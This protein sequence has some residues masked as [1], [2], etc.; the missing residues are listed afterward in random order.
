[1][2]GGSHLYYDSGT[3]VL[4]FVVL[5]QYLD[6]RARERATATLAPGIETARPRAHVVEETGDREVA[7]DKVG[8]GERVRVQRGRKFRSTAE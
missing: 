5:G 1:M 8:R 3:M 2:R 7:P 6:A 4:V